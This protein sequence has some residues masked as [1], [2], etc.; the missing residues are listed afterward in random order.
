[1][2]M[3]LYIV[4][5]FTEVDLKKTLI[6]YMVENKCEQSPLAPCVPAFLMNPKE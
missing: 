2:A 6:G 1:M 3:F 5:P 4:V